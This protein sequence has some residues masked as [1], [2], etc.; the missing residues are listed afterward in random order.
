MS[1]SLNLARRLMG[2]VKKLFQKKV[3]FLRSVSL[4]E[5]LKIDGVDFKQAYND[6]ED[7]EI[8]DL[9]IPFIS[10]DN[11]IKNKESTG[12]DKDILDVKY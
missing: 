12:R 4:Q 11:L 2:L 1:L 9:I 8:E 10:K 6:K 3:L 7:I 5:G